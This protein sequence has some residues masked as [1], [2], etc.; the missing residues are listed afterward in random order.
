MPNDP[1]LENAL[2]RYADSHADE[3]IEL[4]RTLVRTPSENTPPTGAEAACQ[5]FCRSYLESCGFAT[6]LY[7]LSSVAGLTDHPLYFPGRDYTGRPNLAGKLKGGGG[8]SL[9]LSGHIDT[10]PRGT[11]P[12][13]RD[14]FSGHIEKGRLYGRGSND[15]KAGVAANLFVARAF[16]DL[17]IVPGGD[18]IIESVVDEEFGGVNGT[19]AGRVR[20][21]LAG[22]A[23][24]S[25]P[26][27]LRVCPAQRGGRTAHLTFRAP[28]DGILAAGAGPCV[29]SQL[30][31]FLSRVPEFAELRRA[32]APK[33][34]A[35]THLQDPV[36]VSVL[37]ISTGPW[38][39]TEPMAAPTTC[40][41][42]LYWQAMPGE[43]Q[44]QIDSQFHNW[45]NGLVAARPDLFPLPP[46]VEFPI[47]WLPGSSC[48]PH[49]A[50]VEEL[51]SCAAAVAGAPPRVAGIEG[52]CDLFV[53]HGHYGM[54]AALFGPRGGNTHLA[55]EY[56]EI[57]SVI[58]AAKTLLLLAYRWGLRRPSDDG[59]A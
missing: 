24:I 6:D 17:S 5:R 11:L 57:E 50:L 35:Y 43:E 51:S 42:E 31:W 28:N 59:P 3:L 19:L 30:G 48:A 46:Q 47:R 20:G 40:R 27:F 8:P 2:L 1:H 52:P 15:M 29:S 23:V 12:W 7:E 21:Y 58:Q 14:P 39:A 33:H 36:P 56:V 54:P 22:A 9:L 25:E 16:H 37:K 18:L 38:G 26:S 49:T 44:A 32:S 34:F 55:D 41:V 10:A 13:S 53:F 45:L 4:V